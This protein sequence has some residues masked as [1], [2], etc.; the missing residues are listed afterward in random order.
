MPVVIVCPKCQRKVRVPSKALG[1]TVRCP[2]CGDTFEARTDEPTPPPVAPPEVEEAPEA[3]PAASSEPPAP[4]SD[5]RRV[6]RN[7]VGLMALAE[8]LLAGSLA[9][10]L[11]GGL[12]QLATADSAPRGIAGKPAG[13]VPGSLTQILAVLWVMA[14]L[15][16]TAVVLVGSSF[17]S[18]AASQTPLRARAGAVL[19]LAAVA[20]LMSGSSFG[21]ILRGALGGEMGGFRGAAATEFAVA[22]QFLVM[23]MTPLAI[24]AALQ[25]ML[26]IYARGH[27][28]RLRDAAGEQLARGWAFGY[29]V[30]VIGIFV[31]VVLAGIFGSQSHPTFDQVV[32]VLDLLCRTA[33]T[34]VGAFVLWRV[35]TGLGHG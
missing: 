31:L 33:F 35:W 2:V 8:G 3:P 24:G 26:A 32:K 17:A 13:A 34:A 22:G 14:Q 25:T 16:S 4:K 6:E 15:G 23:T 1:K 20:A 28:R 11:V 29:P 10:Q 27:A 18:V 30:I 5:G 7:G 9:L 12:I 21:D 19:V